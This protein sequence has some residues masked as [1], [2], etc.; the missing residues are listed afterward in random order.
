MKG[1]KNIYRKN[2][3][4]ITAFLV[5]I[6]VSLVIA[7]IISYNLTAKYVE[8]EFASKKIEVLD[9]TIKP[10]YDFFQ[11]KIP[12]ITSYQGFLDS[13]SAANYSATVF[14]SYPFV[15]RV[16][17]YD[18]QIGNPTSKTKFSNNAGISVKAIYQYKPKRGKVR[19]VK[20][21]AWSNTDDFRQMA[22]KLSEFISVADT[23]RLPTQD[24]IFRTFYNV[25]PDKI[26]YLN[27]PRR[28]DIRIYK[29]LLKNENIKAFYKQNMMTFLLD[30]HQLKVKNTHPEL[31]QQVTI[32]PVVYDPLDVEEGRKVTEAALTGAF[33]NFK[34][35]FISTDE[36]LSREIDRRFLPIGAIVLLIYFFLVLISWL[37]Y[38]NLNVNLKVFKLQYDFIN[39]FTHEFKTPVSV[40][41]IAGSN[42][43]GDAELSERQ[44]RH[45]GKILDEEADKLNELMNKLLSFT[46]LENKSI[47]VKR[48]EIVLK[49]FVQG[50]IETFKIKYPDFKLEFN[51]EGVTKFHSD[52]V[53]LGSVFQN[54]M[55]NAYKYSHPGKKELF[56]NIKPEKRNIVLSFTDKGIGMARYEQGDVFK[57]FYRIE[58][59][60]NQNGSVGLGLAFCKELVNF[61]NGEID[62]TSKLNVGSAFI[63]TLPLDN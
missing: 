56:I 53:L 30:A 48:E 51:I 24:E 54:L 35:Y 36:H 18:M 44:R 33:S 26:S 8:N 40:I 58:N 3:S 7:V 21:M 31:Y 42:L 22:L 14:K 61:M 55:E 4:L 23:S 46:Q 47:T 17:F 41:K 52:P 2:F 43:K 13:S 45:Y 57:K 37:I 27:I 32:Q 11:I 63:V 9:Q 6:T 62:V 50:Y 10:Y 16:L 25:T 12:E 1:Q 60:Y 49:D 29:S 15:R 5:L 19:G 59:Q 28:E 38:R 39:N 20:D 34:L